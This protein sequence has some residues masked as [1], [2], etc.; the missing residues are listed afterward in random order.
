[1]ITAKDVKVKYRKTNHTQHQKWE[2]YF[3]QIGELHT[4]GII[5]E[6]GVF[7]FFAKHCETLKEAK[8]Y[9]VEYLNAGGNI[10]SI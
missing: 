10:Q 3:F 5:K 1:M 4:F 7:K 6:D 9:I 2:N 8:L